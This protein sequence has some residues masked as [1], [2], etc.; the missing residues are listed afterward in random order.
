MSVTKTKAGTWESRLRQGNG[1]EVSK[2]F[3][4]RALALQWER[5]A[6]TDVDRG[7]FIKI[8]PGR[9][10]VADQTEI[11]LAGLVR[12]T[13]STKYRYEGIIRA[14]ILPAWGSRRLDS[15]GRGDV[16][17]WVA[18]LVED[19]QSPASVAKIVGVLSRILASGLRDNRLA[20]NPV[21]GTEL[22]RITTTKHRYLTHEQVAKLAGTMPT[23]TSALL[24]LVLAYC[25]LRWGELAALR[26]EDADL[27]RRRLNIHRG[28][29]EV[30]GH[31][32]WGEPKD[33][34]RRAVPLPRFLVNELAEHCAGHGRD[35]L[36][37]ASQRGTVLRVRNFRRDSFDRA[38]V[39]IGLE[40]L[41]PHELRH[42]A[43][44]LA[45]S[46]GA[47]A[48][49]VQAMLG[50]ARASMTLDVYADLFPDDLDR[51]ATALDEARTQA[52]TEG[53]AG[54][55]RA[56]GEIVPIRLDH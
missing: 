39:A 6:R 31:L 40:G 18:Q 25:G 34:E 53:G 17:A 20:A 52:L 33:H 4:T 9:T 23:P 29:T 5:N 56:K 12:P 26:V 36:L 55:S 15:I 10:T 38:A 54:I 7:T 44:S 16:Q 2:T 49:A 32:V 42:T 27:L 3:K 24:V 46:A 14:H 41:H 8:Q 30:S 51:V 19:E 22:P 28:V 47:N 50:H 1:R 21:P 11:W 35:E 13:A 48:K 43:A 45:V 37:F